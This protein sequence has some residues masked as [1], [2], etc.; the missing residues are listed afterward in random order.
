[1]LI[2]LLCWV[3]VSVMFCLAMVAAAARRCPSVPEEPMLHVPSRPLKRTL[4]RARAQAAAKVEPVA[5]T[6]TVA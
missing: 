4:V 1:M 6:C 5:T 2:G 3:G